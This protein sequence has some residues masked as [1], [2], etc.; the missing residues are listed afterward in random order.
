MAPAHIPLTLWYCARYH[1]ATEWAP[2]HLVSPTQWLGLCSALSSASPAHL[3]SPQLQAW[4]AP[5]AG[6][7]LCLCLSQLAG[8]HPKVGHAHATGLLRD[9]FAHCRC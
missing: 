6:D 7:R 9:T 4:P 1:V 5:G 2:G 3:A 8:A